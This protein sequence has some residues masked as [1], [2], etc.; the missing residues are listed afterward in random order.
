MDDYSLTAIAVL[1][2]I[3]LPLVYLATKASGRTIG[4]FLGAFILLMMSSWL[5]MRASSQKAAVGTTSVQLTQLAEPNIKSHEVASSEPLGTSNQELWDRLTRSRIDLSDEKNAKE[6]KDQASEEDRSESKPAKPDWVT[7]PPKRVGN[8]YR[9][10]VTS[11]LYS[12]TEECQLHLEWQLQEAVRERIEALVS[13]G[14]ER[15]TLVPEPDSF[16]VS[17][18]YI[19]REICKDEYTETVDAS[20]GK[21]KRVHVLME[22]TPAVEKQLQITWQRFE[23]RRRLTVVGMYAGLVLGLLASIYGLLQFD[24]WTRGYYTKRLLVGVPA[25]IIAVV[26]LAL[27]IS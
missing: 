4:I 25:V 5:F 19:M 1:F 13:E 22:F 2:L 15:S 16:G 6:E 24:T 23:R 17:I 14:A 21:M 10:V 27:F 3:F 7:N 26:V 12:T 20:F 8:V 9:R 11:D 18:G